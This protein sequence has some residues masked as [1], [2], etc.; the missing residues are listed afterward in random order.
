MFF[1]YI[2][3]TFSVMVTG[4]N[5][6]VGA[7][8]VFSLVPVD[9]FAVIDPEASRSLTN[10]VAASVFPVD[11][12]NKDNNRKRPKKQKQKVVQNLPEVL[13]SMICSKV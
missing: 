6:T 3:A 1:G 4:L 7:K 8:C 5:S 12:C 9:C 13:R 2:R 11:H 10:S